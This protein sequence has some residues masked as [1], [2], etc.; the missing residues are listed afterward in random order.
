MPKAKKKITKKLKFVTVKNR[1]YGAPLKGVK[2][3]YIGKKPKGLAKDGS[4]KFGKNV[5]EILRAKFD[6]K[7]HWIITDEINS[8]TVERG[9]HKVRTSMVTLGRLNSEMFDRTRD[10]KMDL[11]RRSFAILYPSYFRSN[12][13]VVYVPG[14]LAPMLAKEI[15]PRLSSEDRDA[16][17]KF[18]PDFIASES[19][20]SV[21][22]LKAETQIESLKDLAAD[23]KKAIDNTHAES[24]WQTYIKKNILIIQQGYIKAIEKM[25]VSIGKTKFPD[26]SLVTHDNYLDILEIKKPTSALMKLD[27]SRGN[28]YWDTEMAKAIIQVENYISN[29]SKYADPVRSYL[30]DEHKISL[31]VLRPRGI[32]LAGDTRK[33]TTQ[34]EKD[35]FRLLCHALKN[36][37]IVTYDELFT[38]LINYIKVLEEFRKIKP[39]KARRIRLTK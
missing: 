36:I 35:D 34:K 21:N 33:F 4:I 1:S 28:Y 14:T 31:Q 37:T 16:L 13:T 38:R 18:L 2:I 32:I 15:L 30:Q 24:W 17:V 6:K 19:H 12:T 7:F 25:N 22:L 9:I 10:I 27:D 3:Y 5:L 20:S 23:F 26:F 29:V 11:I 39:K 8:I